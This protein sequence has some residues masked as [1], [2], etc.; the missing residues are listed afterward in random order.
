MKVTIPKL[1]QPSKGV[2]YHI[3]PIDGGGIVIE[4]CDFGEVSHLCCSNTDWRDQLDLIL[5]TRPGEV[6]EHVG[7]YEIIG[8]KPSE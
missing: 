1:Y 5:E 3:F 6:V 8:I 2:A 7:P 4:V